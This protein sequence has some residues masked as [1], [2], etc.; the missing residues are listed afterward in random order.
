MKKK[1]I[2]AICAVLVSL[3]VAIVLLLIGN[4]GNVSNVNRVV[5][6]SAFYS[7]SCSCSKFLSQ[8]LKIVVKNFSEIVP[9]KQTQMR[10]LSPSHFFDTFD[11]N[12]VTHHHRI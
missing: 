2:I 10:G 1:T 12:N 4:R 5:G 7:E 6:N 9:G 8:I 11:E 3:G